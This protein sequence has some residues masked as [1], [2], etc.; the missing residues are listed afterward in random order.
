[1]TQEQDQDFIRRAIELADQ[2]RSKSNFPFGALLVLDGVIILEAQNTTVT[3]RDRT[4]HAELNLVSTA[5]PKFSH[6][7]LSKATLYTSTEP[8]AMCAGAI[9]WAGVR[10]LVYGLS[11]KTL[12]KIVGSGQKDGHLGVP[13]RLILEQHGVEITGPLLEDEAARVHEGFWQQASS[14]R[15]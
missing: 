1:M 3:D 15:P 14:L 6:A 13:C 12:H 5:G 4:R 2:A 8:C 10:K 11:E 7:E 9:Y